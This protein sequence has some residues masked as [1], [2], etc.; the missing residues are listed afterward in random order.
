MIELAILLIALAGLSSRQ[1]VNAIKVFNRVFNNIAGKTPS[2]QT[3]LDWTF[4]YGLSVVDKDTGHPIDSNEDFSLIIDNSICMNGQEIHL[5]LMADASHKGHALCHS[6]VSLAKMSV[7]KGWRSDDIKNELYDTIG[8]LQKKPEYVVC[9]N[10]KTLIKACRELELPIHHDISHTFGLFLEKIYGKTEELQRFNNAMGF[11]RKFSHTNIGYLMPP[12]RR[13]FAR[14]MNLFDRVDWAYMMSV[15]YELLPREAQYYFR[16]VLEQGCFVTELKEV[17][18]CY[19]SLEKLCKQEGLS[20]S[21][22]A[23]C[24]LLIN[25]TLMQGDERLR[26]LGGMLIRYFNQEESLLK[27][28]DDVHNICSD[29]IESSFGYLKDRMSPN[30]F[31]GFTLMI[32]LIPAHMKAANVDPAESLSIKDYLAD[33][34]IGDVERWRTENLLPNPFSSRPKF[35]AKVV[36]F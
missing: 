12:Q 28:D 32:L 21:T 8:K 20:H 25:S 23:R 3:V 17:M 1:V 16:F 33:V 6:D 11:A 13:R 34:T 5:E 10:G 24:R 18:D 26:T 19:R 14:F 29:V 36:G 2:H 27:S 7:G 4:K 15:N 22:A 30:K 9:D 31:N 35:S